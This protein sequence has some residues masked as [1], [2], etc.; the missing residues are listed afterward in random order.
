MECKP[1]YK[2]SANVAWFEAK[3]LG[4][5]FDGI[6]HKIQAVIYVFNSTTIWTYQ[7]IR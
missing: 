3:H 1:S 7:F 6:T 5:F 2:K 4:L